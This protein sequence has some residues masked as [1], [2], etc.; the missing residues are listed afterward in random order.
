MLKIIFCVYNEEKNLKTFIEDLNNSL[1][2]LKIKY[3]IIICIDGSN[4][5][6]YQILKYFQKNLPIK[7]LDP[8]NQNGL[9]LA[10][11]RIFTEIAKNC[12]DDDIIISLDSDNTHDPKQIDGMIQHLN[13]ND[14][15][16]VICSRFA[17]KSIITKFPLY[18]QIITKTVSK[19][20]QIIFPIKIISQKNLQDYTSGYRAYKA[21]KIKQLYE[22]KGDNFITE[23]EFTYTCEL[24]IKLARIKSKID[25]Y[26]ISYNYGKKNSKSKLKI[27][28][29]FIRLIIMINNLKK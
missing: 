13:N 26:A 23:P 17:N 5:N 29:N 12:Q 14:L 27:I 21:Q 22:L 6:S 1:E 15:D 9:G 18:R 28:P 8:I 24:I 4:D 16:I 19:L 2:K 25:E 3:E 11:K 20:L 10:Y 7:I